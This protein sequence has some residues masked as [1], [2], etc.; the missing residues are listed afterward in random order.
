MFKSIAGN[1]SPIEAELANVSVENIA[2]S[3]LDHS[4][5]VIN[6]TLIFKIN[7][8][9]VFQNFTWSLIERPLGIYPQATLE[10]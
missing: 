6:R 10:I 5:L 9:E 1:H 3:L 8:S 4:N 2:K 7:V